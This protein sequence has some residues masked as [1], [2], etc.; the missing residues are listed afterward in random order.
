MGRP[1]SVDYHEANVEAALSGQSCELTIPERREA[2]QRLR[3]RHGLGVS[4]IAEKLSV[5]T[6]TVY[7]D[8]RTAT[9]MPA[10]PP[11]PDRLSLTH[12]EMVDVVCQ[13]A[14]D[15]RDVD[16]Q[17]VFRQLN[18]YGSREIVALL[19]TA[20]A[21]IPDDVPP[22]QLLAWTFPLAEDGAA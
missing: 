15:V 14:A 22:Q 9:G 11:D 7:G 21:M 17:V 2:V 5:S 12:D 6:A 10:A 8:L 16:P 19:Y 3:H 18:R 4:E 20:A 13:L 1:K